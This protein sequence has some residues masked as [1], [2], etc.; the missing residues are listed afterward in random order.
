MVFYKMLTERKEILA[1]FQEYSSDG[2]KL[3]VCDLEDF[4]REEQ[5]EGDTSQQ[6]A[7]ELIER[8]EPSQK[9]TDHRHHLSCFFY[10]SAQR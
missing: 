8:Y 3:S 7:L 2:K 10:S 9:G 1:L 5:Q 4:L 6:H